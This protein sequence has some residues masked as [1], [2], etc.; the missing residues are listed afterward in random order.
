MTP[1]LRQM[2]AAGASAEAIHEAAVK[3]GMVDLR[4]YSA[5]L[6]AEG[7][8]TVEEVTSVVSMKD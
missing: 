2:V 4:R 8:T 6:L 3:D 7:Q 1:A 5:L